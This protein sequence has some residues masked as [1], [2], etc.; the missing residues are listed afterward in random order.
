MVRRSG[1]S[2]ALVYV[3]AAAALGAAPFKLY[4]G[5]HEDDW[6]R[7]QVA[8]A[9]ATAAAAAPHRS[10]DL[11]VT[12]DPYD[13]VF[14]FYSAEGHEDETTRR[15]LPMLQRVLPAGQQ[16]HMAV[17]I[18]DGAPSLSRSHAW[19]KVQRPALVD[20][21]GHEVRDITMIEVVRD[22]QR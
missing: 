20:L 10:V 6:S 1:M 14:A 17:F 18:L 19:V 16:L 2:L 9:R 4:P 12:D 8:K 7:T 21:G 13:R 15:M 22:Q 3:G 5:A 11:Y